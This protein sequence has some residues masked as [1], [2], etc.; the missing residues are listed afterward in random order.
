MEFDPRVVTSQVR[1]EVEQIIKEHSNSFE[2]AVIYRA[3][4]AAGPLADWVKALLKFSEVY[5]QIRPLE[6]KQSKLE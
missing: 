5:E 6:Q 1:R 3:S 2:T 4:A